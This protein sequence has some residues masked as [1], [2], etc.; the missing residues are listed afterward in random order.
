MSELTSEPPAR[1]YD[2]DHVLMEDGRIFRVLGNLAAS[3]VFLGYNLY[4]PS[5]EGDRVFRGEPY[6]KNYIEDTVLPTD[7]METYE[8]LRTADVVE[9]FDPIKSAQENNHSYQGTIW[10]E[11]YERLVRHFGEASVGIFG[12]A[13]PGLHLGTTGTLKNDV[14]YFIEG[15]DNVPKL[16][17]YLPEVREHLGFSDYS[18][19]VQYDIHNTWRRVFRN[20]NNSLEKIIQRRWSGM[21][22]DG[23]GA[24]PVLNTFRFRDKEVKTPMELM[25]SEN[26]IRQNV[27]LRGTVA[28]D[29]GGNLYPR[30]FNLDLGHKCTPVYSFWWKL[31]SPVRA[32]DSVILTGD[33]IGLHDQEA[34]RLTNYVNHSIT[35]TS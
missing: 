25:G 32:G 28:D 16:A 22:Y 2:M 1:L 6:I 10:F 26:T 19:A 8:V 3:D 20:P 12:S 29:I 27:T 5:A 21:Q 31:S 23:P 4:S 18:A 24:R 14:D 30:V 11:L 34:L 33:M 15:L 9:F 7:V 13:L 35:I 17:E